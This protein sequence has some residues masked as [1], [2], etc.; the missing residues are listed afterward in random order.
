VRRA[1]LLPPRQ[2]GD[3]AR[4]LE[5]AV[6]SPRRELQLGQRPEWNGGLGHSEC[7]PDSR[8][9]A[10]LYISSQTTCLQAVFWEGG[11]R[12][13]REGI[14]L[15]AYYSPFRPCRLATKIAGEDHLTNVLWQARI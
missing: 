10:V 15:R 1:D 13:M 12:G 6:V 8:F 4:Q 7:R 2:I 3:G 14:R 5:D 11:S 9:Q